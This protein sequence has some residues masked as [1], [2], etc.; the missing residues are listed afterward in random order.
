MRAYGR[1]E[2]IGLHMVCEKY[3]DCAD[4]MVLGWGRRSRIAVRRLMKKRFRSLLKEQLR[5]ETI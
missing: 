2:Y 5:R 4:E 3:P 1:N